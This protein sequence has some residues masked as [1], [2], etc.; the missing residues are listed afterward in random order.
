[1]VFRTFLDPAE[2]GLLLQ[3]VAAG[4]V[5]HHAIGLGL[6]A[7]DEADGQERCQPNETVPAGSAAVRL[8]VTVRA[9][10]PAGP[11]AVTFT[12]PQGR[13]AG[14]SRA[15]LR[16]GP[17]RIPIGSYFVLGD[18]RVGSCDSRRWGPLPRG[19]II[20]RVIATYWPPSRIALH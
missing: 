12:S 1:M 9:D 5:E 13:L 8:F 6:L 2:H 10:E 17:V 14:R 3:G 4:E 19:N 20:G 7:P 18:N 16:S 15:A 11:L